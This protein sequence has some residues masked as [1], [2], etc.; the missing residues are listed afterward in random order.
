MITMEPESLKR[1]YFEL[2]Y[3]IGKYPAVA[4]LLE[5]CRS[6]PYTRRLLDG[7]KAWG[8]GQELLRLAV[9]HG[10]VERVKG[11]GKRVY[12]RLTPLGEEVL[13]F[14]KDVGL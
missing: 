7:L 14:L 4:K 6:G 13:E 2:G 11:E 9:G 8:N 3:L 5:L 12:N 10:L 1:R